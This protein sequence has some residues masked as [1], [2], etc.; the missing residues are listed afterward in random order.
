MQK[1]GSE[2][3]VP[4]KEETITESREIPQRLDQIK[5]NLSKKL[6]SLAFV[7]KIVVPISIGWLAY[8]ASDTGNMIAGSQ[9]KSSTKIAQAQLKLADAEYALLESQN[10]REARQVDRSFQ[11][12]LLEIF[13]DKISQPNQNAQLRA[14]SLLRLMDREFAEKL[15]K[16]VQ[17]DPD[18]GS[19]IH[20]AARQ[21][22][23]EILK[24]VEPNTLGKLKA[25]EKIDG[26]IRERK[27]SEVLKLD[28]DHVIAAMRLIQELVNDG[29][30]QEAA[31]HL[32]HLRSGLPSVVPH[33]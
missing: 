4:V 32:D 31:S 24:K 22:T 17:N 13:H 10:Q 14:L 27:Y 11:L 6:S 21:I 28:P 26:L 2:S 9:I 1:R 7:E 8:V 33:K 15:G 5:R 16:W 30:Y 3:E 23:S 20:E 25:E 18:F 12:K 19:S 29:R